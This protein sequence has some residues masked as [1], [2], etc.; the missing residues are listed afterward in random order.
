MVTLSEF[1]PTDSRGRFQ[2][3]S[4][5]CS[6]SSMRKGN[7]L[8]TRCSTSRKPG[9]NRGSSPR[10]LVLLNIKGGVRAKAQALAPI[11]LHDIVCLTETWLTEFDAPVKFPSHTYY[12]AFRPPPEGQGRPSR[13]VSVYV[14]NHLQA[15]VAFVKQSDAASYLWLK[16]TNVVQDC[17]KC[18]FVFVTC[19]IGIHDSQS[20]H[21]MSI[22]R[23]TVCSSKQWELRF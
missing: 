18:I 11:L 4:C 7:G 17:L 2:C 13:G 9:D 15:H 23:R 6:C 1:A 12:S 20:T 10:T 16:L 22:C 21:H 19:L 14:S 8:S 5:S 3:C